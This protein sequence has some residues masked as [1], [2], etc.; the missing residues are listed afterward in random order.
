MKRRY[1]F[2][3]TLGR[4]LL[5]QC[6]SCVRMNYTVERNGWVQSSI[7][8][9]CRIFMTELFYEEV[10]WLQLSQ[11][12]KYMQLLRDLWSNEPTNPLA[13]AGYSLKWTFQLQILS[14]HV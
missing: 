1:L 3:E 6:R 10:R 9:Y 4:L 2:E 7:V 11:A 8:A 12:L 5:H 13:Y 14:F